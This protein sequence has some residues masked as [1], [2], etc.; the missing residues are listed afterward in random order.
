MSLYTDTQF[1]LKNIS[2]VLLTR[3]LYQHVDC[4]K[5]YTEY[6]NINVLLEPKVISL[7]HKHHVLILTSLK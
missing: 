2:P 7:S 1:V 6:S 5:L 4:I 3:G